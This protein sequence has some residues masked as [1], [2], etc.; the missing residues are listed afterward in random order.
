MNQKALLVAQ[1]AGRAG[2]DLSVAERTMSTGGGWSAWGKDS[3]PTG[4][5]Y[6]QEG[7][8]AEYKWLSTHWFMIR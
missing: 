4:S 8:C 1:E 7:Q 5:D 6:R 2:P 3:E